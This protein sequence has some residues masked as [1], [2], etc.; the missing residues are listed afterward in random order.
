MYTKTE[1][2]K[3]ILFASIRLIICVGHADG[4]I[5]NKEVS[6]IHEL[7][8]SEHFT[9]RER[10]ILM[11]DMDY[12]KQPETIVKDMVDLSLPEKLGLLRQLYKIALV[13]QKL[14]LAETLEI[15]R[16]SCLLGISEEKQKQVEEWIVEGIQWRDRWKEIVGE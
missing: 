16:I 8:N 9:L 11:D 6:R 13:D 4:Y 15:R 12:P 14:S 1:K 3:H 10:Q 7:V 5:G 2:D